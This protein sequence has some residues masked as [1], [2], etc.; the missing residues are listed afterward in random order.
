MGTRIYTGDDS[1]SAYDT[2][3]KMSVVCPTLS[4]STISLQFSRPSLVL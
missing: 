1:T 2:S 4:K 3:R